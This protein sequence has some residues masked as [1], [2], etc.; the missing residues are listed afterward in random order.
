MQGGCWPRSRL[1]EV[2]L[3]HLPLPA[4]VSPGGGC[5][6]RSIR[7]L[8]CEARAR[9]R[10]RPSCSMPLAGGSACRL[11]A[12][13]QLCR[14]LW[15]CFAIIPLALETGLSDRGCRVAPAG[16]A[17]RRH[18]LRIGSCHRHQRDDGSRPS[19]RDLCGAKGDKLTVARPGHR[20]SSVSRHGLRRAQG[21]RILSV[22][23]LTPRKGHDGLIEALAGD[24][25]AR[26]HPGRCDI[27][28]PPLGSRPMPINACTQIRSPR[29]G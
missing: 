25:P 1:A 5:R 6:I 26:S 4:R 3:T 16:R 22:G 29:Q 23:S 9:G 20:P 24:A 28:G 15:S 7:R 11:H 10:A 27:I 13:A 18:S 19:I 14:C 17:R 21:L 12:L 8:R 2:A